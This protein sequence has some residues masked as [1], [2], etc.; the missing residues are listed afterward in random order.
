VALGTTTT[1]TA[2]AATTVAAS[3]AAAAV[4]APTTGRSG[5][6]IATVD[7]QQARDDARHILAGRRY[8]GAPVPRPLHGVLRW[9][10][11]RFSPITQWIGDRFSWLPSYSIPWIEGAAV[12]I[13]LLMIA[14]FVR[15]MVRANARAGPLDV[16]AAGARAATRADDPDAL[17]AAATEAEARGDLALAVR[18]RFRAG[19]MRLDRDA[20]AI[21]YRP[22]IPT[23]D[24]RSELAS[25]AFDELADTFESI[26]YGSA[27][28]EPDDT[29][30][31]RR[32]WPRVVSAARRK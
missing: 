11:D 24:V 3:P 12:I 15:A 17:E 18:L 19:L 1:R 29:A 26:T 22:S 5:T 10:G 28:A 14:A 2:A 16:D 23:T 8:R 20:H 9:L 25:P 4:G 21:A 31:A 27:P 32:E 6:V 13:V 30:D 7:P